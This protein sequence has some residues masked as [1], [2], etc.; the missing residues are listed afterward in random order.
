MWMGPRRSQ[1]AFWKLFL[2]SDFKKTPT[3]KSIG[4]CR[5][6][7]EGL[8]EDAKRNFEGYEGVRMGGKGG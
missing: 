1:V 3:G 8:Q 2:Q 5:G 6:S 4:G 7:T